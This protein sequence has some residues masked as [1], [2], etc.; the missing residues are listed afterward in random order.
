MSDYKIA[1]PFIG[2]P[3][4]V[5]L[6]DTVQK[7]PV[8]LEVRAVDMATASNQ[9]GGAV[10]V[11]CQ[12]SNVSSAGQWV[13][14]VNGSAVLMAAAN[15]GSGYPV[16]VAAGTLSATSNYGWVQIAGVCDYAKGTSGAT[17]LALTAGSGAFIVAG[18]AGFIQGVSIAGNRIL[19]V[20]ILSSRASDATTPVY[21]SL[22]RPFVFALTGAI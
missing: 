22:N 3:S 11:Y 1:D 17:N 13:N 15:S 5:S 6:A 20:N 19:G 10:F 2:A 18:T 4:P 8:G 12:G 14:I 21:A 9:L 16:G 7:W